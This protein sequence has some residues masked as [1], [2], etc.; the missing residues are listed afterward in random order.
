MAKQNYTEVPYKEFITELKSKYDSNRK[1]TDRTEVDIA[2]C[3]GKSHMT[4]RNC[5]SFQEQV[6]S[7][8][9]LTNLMKCIDLKGKIEWNMGEKH[10]YIFK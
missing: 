4:V 1:E 2:V 9:I 7:D 5:I 3:I 8:K 10:Y 6:V